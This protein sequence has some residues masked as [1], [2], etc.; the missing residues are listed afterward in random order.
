MQFKHFLLFTRRFRLVSDQV[1]MNS[2]DGETDVMEPNSLLENLIQTQST[3]H[4]SWITICKTSFSVTFICGL[5]VAAVSSGCVYFSVMFLELCET[6]KWFKQYP[7]YQIIRIYSQCLK[8][9]LLQ[10]SVPIS[11]LFSL[12]LD[13]NSRCFIILYNL[14][15]SCINVIYRLSTQV[16]NIYGKNT[17]IGTPQFVVFLFM[18]F[19]TTGL[20][21]AKV[22]SGRRKKLKL[23]L[24]LC[25]QFL[26]ALA[27]GY[28]NL[29]VFIPWHLQL[30][31]TPK[32]I[33]AT[34]VPSLGYLSTFLCE[35]IITLYA[36]I[37]PDHKLF[38]LSIS[39]KAVC[40]L[41]YRSYQ[42][43]INTLAQYLYL[44]LLHGVVSFIEKLFSVHILKMFAW[45][46]R[47]MC[48]CS[49][50]TTITARTKTN[51]MNIVIT[52]IILEIWGIAV[53]NLF[54]VFYAV[55][56]RI[57]I[58]GE[59]H[60]SVSDHMLDFAKKMSF[61]ILLEYI[62]N[63]LLIFYFT[64]YLNLQLAY[65]KKMKIYFTIV[66]LINSCM[67]ILYFAAHLTM[68][69]QDAFIISLT[70]D[71]QSELAKLLPYCNTSFPPY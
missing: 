53:S 49:I 54:I 48:N 39:L 46:A 35:R 24:V 58:K 21:A 44:S 51:R 4:E 57:P 27:V 17:L 34:V 12:K 18:L 14:L 69:T 33:V 31:S 55:Q 68:L 22:A 42:A 38:T 37:V 8:D 40:M 41:F 16:T 50:N 71:D 15:A 9:V 23:F 62:F 60:F 29:F 2:Q 45:M 64:R 43:H 10:C 7:E 56:K 36:E 65:W 6:W 47:K 3:S 67:S 19:F 13:G 52:S 20:T 5:F 66:I 59:N 1:N 32:L 63:V 61:S 26:F 28:L 11:F 70:N 25:M 30:I